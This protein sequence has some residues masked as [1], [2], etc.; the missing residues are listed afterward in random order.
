MQDLL[1]LTI[2]AYT[3]MTSFTC[4]G[5]CNLQSPKQMDCFK[6]FMKQVQKLE[7]QSSSIVKDTEESL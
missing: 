2:L 5:V 4:S 6:V 1:K 3:Q 7:D